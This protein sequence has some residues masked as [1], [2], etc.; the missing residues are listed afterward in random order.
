M[1]LFDYDYDDLARQVQEGLERLGVNFLRSHGARITR[2]QLDFHGVEYVDLE[3]T[4]DGRTLKV[5]QI[6]RPRGVADAPTESGPVEGE[7]FES[8]FDGWPATNTPAEDIARWLAGLPAGEARPETARPT[9]SV[10][11][12]FGA[13]PPRASQPSRESD[14]NP[15]LGGGARPSGANPFADDERER[16]R[17][18]ALRRL[19]G[20]D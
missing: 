20:D 12:P 17:Q 7:T 15:F 13:S 14:F 16:K 11:N 2:D 1:S 5:H 3:L 8:S 6:G 10:D 9:A 19:K 18:D 4:H